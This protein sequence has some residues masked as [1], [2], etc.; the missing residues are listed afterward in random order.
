MHVDDFSLAILHCS[1][2]DALLVAVYFT[3]LAS[4]GSELQS[5]ELSL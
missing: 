3:S 2:F 1:T 5:T 4:V